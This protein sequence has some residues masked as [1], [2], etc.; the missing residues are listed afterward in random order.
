MQKTQKIKPVPEKIMM[1]QF[2]RKKTDPVCKGLNSAV[3]KSSNFL[4]PA[5]LQK[6]PQ[7]NNNINQN[8]SFICTFKQTNTAAASICKL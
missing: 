2:W 8:L 5:H 4:T 7:N 1:D 6:N 3:G